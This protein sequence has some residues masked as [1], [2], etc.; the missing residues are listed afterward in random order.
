[1]K[2]ICQQI[3]FGLCVAG[4]NIPSFAGITFGN[5]E[6]DTGALT[7]SGAL[8]GSYTD[9]HYGE[10]A[11]DQKIKFDTA[12]LNLAYESPKW[13][14]KLD[15]RCYQYDQLC[16]FSTLVYAYAGY[17]INATDDITLGLQPVPFGPSRYWD[18][19]FYEGINNTMGL[20]DALNLGASYHFELPSKTQFDL[21][22]FATDGGNYHGKSKDSARY[23]ANLVQT[24]DPATTQLSEKNMWI[25]RVEQPLSFL[26]NDDFKMSVGGSYWYSEIENKKNAQDGSRKAWSLFGKLNYQN[27]N[28]VLT[29][30]KLDINSKDTTHPY[31]STLGSFDSEYDLANKGYFYTLDTTY[32]FKNVRDHLNITPYLVISGY[33]KKQQGFATSQRN[34]VGLAWDYKQ[35]LLYTEYVMSKNDPFIGGSSNSL[36]AGDDNKWNKLVNVV[37]SYN[38]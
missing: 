22:Y 33:D 5:A 4:L 11:S 21:A 14:G 1:M 31:S 17:H 28:I 35:I 19:S 24:S 29:G 37:L 25:A 8:R 32:T 3:S 20:E 12:I 6:S 16:D 2:K 34:I 30:G 36:A 7:I 9:K 27:L 10:A 38:F 18:S 13:F 15:Y 26:N 23:T